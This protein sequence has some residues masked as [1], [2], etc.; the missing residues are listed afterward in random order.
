MKNKI[1][2]CALRSILNPKCQDCQY[3]LKRL[4]GMESI[5]INHA[6]VL[7]EDDG[8]HMDVVE[9]DV[10]IA[11]FDESCYEPHKVSKPQVWPEDLIH[12]DKKDEA[13]KTY[14]SKIQ[15]FDKMGDKNSIGII[16]IFRPTPL[17]RWRTCPECGKHEPAKYDEIEL[18]LKCKE[19]IWRAI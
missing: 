19:K 8:L 17:P 12:G 11:Y 18:C 6:I 13:A 7:Y 14:L 15:M 1:L 2:E 10:C 5:G 16:G 3:N 4:G 9:K